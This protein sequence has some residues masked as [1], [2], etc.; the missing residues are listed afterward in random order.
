MAEVHHFTNGRFKASISEQSRDDVYY[1]GD[2]WNFV[3]EESD[4]SIS[5]AIEF[6]DE[7]GIV[8]LVDFTQEGLEEYHALL[9]RVLDTNGEPVYNDRGY[10][11]TKYDGF[12]IT[13]VAVQYVRKPQDPNKSIQVGLKYFM[14][15]GTANSFVNSEVGD[16]TVQTPSVCHVIFK[17]RRSSKVY[18][19]ETKTSTEV[20]L[21]N[22]DLQ[23][24]VLG[25]EQFLAVDGD[26]DKVDV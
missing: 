25:I 17:T 10:E 1:L 18:D 11:R 23:V 22:G 26:L 19:R 2:N 13:E 15:P 24:T 12:G 20:G 5:D 4:V 6:M 9:Q 8:P 3:P 16:V 14:E 7:E 21:N